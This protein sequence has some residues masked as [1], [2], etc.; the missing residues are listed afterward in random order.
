MHMSIVVILAFAL[1]LGG[2]FISPQNTKSCNSTSTCNAEL[3]N[4]KKQRQD[5]E[6]RRDA[7]KKQAQNIQGLISDIQSDISYT[8]GRIDNT[9]QQ[10]TITNAIL[11][12]LS[13]DISGLE[14]KLSSAYVGLYEL[15]RASTSET[16]LQ[17]SLNDTITR[18]Q[19]IQAIQTQLQKEIGNL[20]QSKTDQEQQ[21]KS[22]EELIAGLEE[23]RSSLATKKS[24]QSYL[25]AGAKRD[26]A[27]YANLSAEIQSKIADVEKRLSL[28]IAQAS[29]G[30]DIVSVQD[31]SWYYRQLDYPQYYVQPNPNC[32]D[33]T[34]AKYGCLITSYAMVS[35]YHGTRVTPLDIA[36]YSS[37]NFS[38]NGFLI[39]QPPLPTGLSSVSTSPVNWSRV[40]SE[41]DLGHPIIASIYI[42]SLGAPWNQDGSHHFVVIYGRAGGKYFMHDPLGPGRSYAL[43]NVR[44]MKI[45]R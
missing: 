45:I 32:Y 27:S 20:Q 4:L 36:Q 35:T 28:L 38:S 15:S 30:S 26:A 6:A 31:P 14:A 10:I 12:Q 25:L 11:Q 8:E 9:E 1:L 21:R 23:E 3:L 24:Q 39:K 17:T 33:C 42:P 7:S 34:I 5:A 43:G 19:Y 2:L 41:V 29:W 22:L 18:A 40:N 37:D 16:I 13:S 44:S